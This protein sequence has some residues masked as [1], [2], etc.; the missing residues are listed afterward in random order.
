MWSLKVGLHTTKEPTLRDLYV[1][2]AVLPE[3]S[4]SRDEVRLSESES[5]V[6]RSWMG[7]MGACTS[8]GRHASCCSCSVYPARR[9]THI[10]LF[11]TRM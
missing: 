3:V 10:V 6:Y 2:L 4:E 11:F 5:P 9:K 1:T 7:G 8:T